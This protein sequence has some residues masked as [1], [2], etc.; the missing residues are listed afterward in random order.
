MNLSMVALFITFL[1]IY[2]PDS[3]KEKT[4][5]SFMILFLGII[6][7]WM[8]TSHARSVLRSANERISDLET[9]ILEHDQN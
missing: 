7:M 6:G 5:H 4:S 3:N 9:E 2:M 1:W 8:W